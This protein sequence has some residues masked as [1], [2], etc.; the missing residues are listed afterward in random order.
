[1]KKPFKGGNKFSGH[2]PSGGSGKFGKPEGGGDSKRRSASGASDKRSAK[3]SPAGSPIGSPTGRP[4]SRKRSEKPA[5]GGDERPARGRSAA[6]KGRPGGTRLKG[7]AA[8]GR[9]PGA[10]RTGDAAKPFKTK[11]DEKPASLTGEVRLNKY[12]ANSGVASRRE[13]DALIAEGKV[14]VNGK[15]VTELGTKVG[16]KDTVKFDGKLMRPEKLVYVLLN[17]PRDF[18]TTVTDPQNRRTVMA[19]VK[20]ACDERIYPVGRLDRNTSGLL[21]FT[22]DGDLAKK[23]AHPSHLVKKIYYV[24]LNKPLRNEDLAKIKAGLELQDG[25]V[26]PDDIQIVTPDSIG[27]GI[28]IHVG[29]N[30]IVRRIFEYLGYDVVKLD[31]VMYGG[32]TKKDLARGNWRHLTK[33]EINMLKNFT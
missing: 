33:S 19:L 2:K 3:G 14:T 9:K 7:G 10:K 17:K 27:I 16:P 6:P 30:R 12:L 18:I 29:R 26:T 25:P 4:V 8:P 23:L 11:Y 22:N 1:M 21:L 20:N 13:A 24:E 5:D 15:V 31:R 28:E 32:L